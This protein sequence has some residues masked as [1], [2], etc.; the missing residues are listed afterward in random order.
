MKLTSE[1][2][3]TK[4]RLHLDSG[5]VL[6]LEARGVD[7]LQHIDRFL[8]TLVQLREGGLVVLHWD[9]L[10]TA[11]ADR[12]KLG[13]VRARLDLEWQGL[14]TTSAPFKPD[15]NAADVKY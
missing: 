13:A 14:C 4:G 8:D 1:L 2:K 6:A 5:V 3:V 9:V 11:H 12:C 7:L 15:H 10:D